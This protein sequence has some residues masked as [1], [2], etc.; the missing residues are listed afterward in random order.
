MKQLFAQMNI[1]VAAVLDRVNEAEFAAFSE[2]I[3]GAARIFVAGEGRSGLMGKAF[4]MRL[5][6]AGFNAYVIG[7]TITPSIEPGDV[8]V[9][10]SGSGTTE[11]VLLYANQAKKI[12]ASVML[13]TTNRNSKIAGYSDLTLRIPAATKLRLE[14][15]PPT[16]QPLGN[17]F[18]QSL[19]MLLDAVIIGISVEAG[20]GSYQEMARRHTNLQ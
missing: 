14:D 20:D 3:K 1:E 15:E 4:A 10:I 7:E 2:G 17:Q 9:A 5:M 8:L 13:I 11:A 18:D 19:H 6:H 12:G 16:I